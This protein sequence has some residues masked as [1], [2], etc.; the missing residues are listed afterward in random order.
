MHGKMSF[1]DSITGFVDSSMGFVD[2]SLDFM[3]SSMGF[4]HSSMNV[5]HSEMSIPVKTFTKALNKHVQYVVVLSYR[6]SR[7]RHNILGQSEP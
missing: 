2:S 1:V 6:S 7:F 5:M 4:V 3:D